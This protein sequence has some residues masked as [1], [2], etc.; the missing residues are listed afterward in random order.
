MI[1]EVWKSLNGVVENGDHYE[2]SNLGRVRSIDRTIVNALG[3]TCFFKS[4]MIKGRDNEDGYRYVGLALNGKTKTLYVHRLV[5][6][7]FI[8]NPENKPEV[9]HCDGVKSNNHVD[10]LEWSTTHEN[11]VHARVTG[12]NKGNGVKGSQ[13]GNARLTEKDVIEIKRLL[14]N[15]EKQ[16]VIAQMFGVKECTI[17]QINTGKKWKHITLQ[18]SSD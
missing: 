5:A 2:V 13:H 17:S 10:N 12:L 14:S 9:N 1:G 18:E 7:A 11:I 8:P 6:L 16:K 15:K 4:K 3:R